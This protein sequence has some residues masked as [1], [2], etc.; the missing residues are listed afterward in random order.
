MI[1][2][3]V[4]QPIPMTVWKGYKKLG[5]IYPKGWNGNPEIIYEPVEPKYLRHLEKEALELGWKGIR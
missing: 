5:T 3:N 4:F 2:E 1:T